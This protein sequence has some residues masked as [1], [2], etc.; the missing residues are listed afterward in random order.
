MTTM[1]KGCIVV[2]SRLAI[3][4]ATNGEAFLF[5][6]E[7]AFRWLGTPSLLAEGC[8]IRRFPFFLANR[9]EEAGVTGI[10]TVT[11]IRRVTIKHGAVN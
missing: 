5:D 2:L 8:Q 3:C 10:T 1:C 11:T 9:A 4:Y 6:T 7:C